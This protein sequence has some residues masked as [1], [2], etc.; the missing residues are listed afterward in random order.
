[1]FYNLA[2][3]YYN[4]ASVLIIIFSLLKYHYFS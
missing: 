2:Q 1:M 4:I 3:Y